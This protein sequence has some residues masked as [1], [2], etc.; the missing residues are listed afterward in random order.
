MT[1]ETDAGA[2]W[3]ERVLLLHR[4]AEASDA[5]LDPGL[6]LPRAEYVRADLH[7]AALARVEALEAELRVIDALDPEERISGFSESAALGGRHD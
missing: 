6:Q 3:P 7:A 1:A 2:Q 5:A 4:V